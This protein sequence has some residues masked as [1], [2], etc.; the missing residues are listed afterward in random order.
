MYSHG[1]QSTCTSQPESVQQAVQELLSYLP[2]NHL[3]QMLCED[4]QSI[5]H[6]FA[7]LSG[8][9]YDMLS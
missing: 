6:E 4:M 9:S 3:S 8:T 7:N 5:I 1:M 2:D